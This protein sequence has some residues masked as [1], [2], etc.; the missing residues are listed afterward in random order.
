MASRLRAFE[1]SVDVLQNVQVRLNASSAS[2]SR[3]PSPTSFASPAPSSAQGPW[4]SSSRTS[5]RRPKGRSP[6]GPATSALAKTGPD[7]RR[8]GELRDDGALDNR[9]AAAVGR[10]LSDPVAIRPPSRFR[11]DEPDRLARPP[12]RMRATRFVYP[13]RRS[14]R[15]VSRHVSPRRK[16]LSRRVECRPNCAPTKRSC[17]GRLRTWK[18]SAFRPQGGVGG[19][20][21]HRP[22]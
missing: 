21:S 14:R 2:G 13:S 3:P 20:V 16:L 5:R 1:D 9:G 11:G 15:Q 22:S 6:M 4:T 10:R 7:E 18:P 8:G 19:K 12:A 17:D